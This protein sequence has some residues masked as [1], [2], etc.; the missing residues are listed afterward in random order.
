MPKRSLLSV[1][2]VEPALPKPAR[3]G[4]AAT[5]AKSAKARP[6]AQ[7][8]TPGMADMPAEALAQIAAYFQMLSE[9]SRLR[10]LNLLRSEPRRVGDLALLC[11]TTAANTSK[12]LSQLQA[13]GLVERE[14]Q[15]TSVYYRI[16]DPQVYALCDLVCGLIAK[17]SERL[18]SARASFLAP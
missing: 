14:S 15:G 17:Q 13:Q 18:V 6:A 4:K 10:I 2:P 3:V 9:P 7:P 1:A 8:P 5:S 16:A 11:G 12:H